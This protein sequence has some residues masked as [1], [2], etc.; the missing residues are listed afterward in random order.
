MQLYEIC[1]GI[2]RTTDNYV[3]ETYGEYTN[4]EELLSPAGDVKAAFGCNFSIIMTYGRTSYLDKLMGLPEAV[5]MII[6]KS[7][8]D[9]VFCMG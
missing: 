2:I 1:D 7:L 9:S 8:M 6:Q 3:C 5:I 4:S